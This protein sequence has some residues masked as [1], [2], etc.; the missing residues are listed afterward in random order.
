MTDPEKVLLAIQCRVAALRD[1][2]FWRLA[3]GGETLAY[4]SPELRRIRWN[5]REI[6]GR[7]LDRTE[8]HHVTQSLRELEA[9]GCI[10]LICNANG[11]TV[12]VELTGNPVVSDAE[13][14]AFDQRRMKN[15][16]DEVQATIARAEELLARYRGTSPMLDC[17]AAG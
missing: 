13:R 9:V 4:A 15:F 6:F 11:R 1:G 2:R 12:A 3:L 8:R 17:N 16:I 10:E 7:R 14:E 5:A